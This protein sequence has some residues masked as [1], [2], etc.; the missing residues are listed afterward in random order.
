[1]F[2][3]GAY[4]RHTICKNNRRLLQPYVMPDEEIAFIKGLCLIGAALFLCRLL[5]DIGRMLR[6]EI[7]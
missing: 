7:Q 4:L 6:W 3:D 1:V 2:W 5:F